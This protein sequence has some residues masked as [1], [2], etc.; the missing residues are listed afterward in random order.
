MKIPC[1]S[2]DEALFEP[3]YDE[4]GLGEW[5]EKRRGEEEPSLEHEEQSLEHEEQSV[6]PEE[7]SVEHEK[8]PVEPEGVVVTVGGDKEPSVG[9]REVVVTGHSVS[10]VVTK[11]DS[12]KGTGQPRKRRRH[13]NK[14]KSC[15]LCGDVV[16]SK[17]KRH[18]G[19]KHLPWYFDPDQA[20][21][22]CQVT[23]QGLCFVRNDHLSKARCSG[24]GF[25]EFRLFLWAA[26]MVGVLF[27]LQKCVGTTS[28]G[29]LL[30]WI[31]DQDRVPDETTAISPTR[32]ALLDVL[33]WF[34][35]ESRPEEYEAKPSTLAGILQWGVIVRVAETLDAE[36]QAGL[37]TLLDPR[38]PDGS[39]ATEEAL[40]RCSAVPMKFGDAHCHL[41]VLQLKSHGKELSAIQEESGKGRVWSFAPALD[42]RLFISNYVFPGCW[43]RFR[44]GVG[45]RV[46]KTVGVHPKVVHSLSNEQWTLVES[47][48]RDPQCVGIGE[49]GLDT[50][51]R[52]TAQEQEVILRRQLRV[53]VSTKKPVVL[54]IRGDDQS[55]QLSRAFQVVSG[56]LPKD[57]P[58]YL[59]CYTGTADDLKTWLGRFSK[60]LV[61]FSGLV[62]AR[63]IHSRLLEA[64]R[65]PTLDQLAVETDSPYLTPEGITRGRLNCPW[66]VDLVAAVIGRERNLPTRVVLEATLKNLGR[67]YH[68]FV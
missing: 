60:L 56:I 57:H 32:A 21:W 14:A 4:E 54:H 28:L 15:S 38:W 65:V 30:T 46:L 50:G 26:Y 66:Y 31:R 64:T 6:E 59:H 22:E 7:Q 52:A 13:K 9:T 58:V 68:T 45:R 53:A 37:L 27:Y 16:S 44:E 29:G 62:T 47:L 12:N 35:G 34:L 33:A 39:V 63:T 2:M 51:A 3:D 20:C 55:A 67:F 40:A 1:C 49:C 18:V 17:M 11:G 19:F 48:M 23:T 24:G 42:A 8:E 36:G 25:T 61:G 41:T 10:V 5:E 43:H